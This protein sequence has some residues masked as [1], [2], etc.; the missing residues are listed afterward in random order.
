[1]Q[2]T[3]AGFVAPH[4]AT[5]A[6]RETVILQAG[7]GRLFSAARSDQ[8][9][10]SSAPYARTRGQALQ[11]GGPSLARSL[12][13]SATH[14]VRRPRC[15]LRRSPPSRKCGLQVPGTLPR[16]PREARWRGLCGLQGRPGG[17]STLA[18]A[19]LLAYPE[20]TCPAEMQDPHRSVSVLI[21]F[22]KIKKQAETKTI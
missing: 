2:V 10:G 4:P 21:H 12:Q 16:S 8:E 19:S 11:S 18:A 15:K 17:S 22:V 20:T 3:A 7:G 14:G 9:A 13:R 6:S 1:M 5:Q